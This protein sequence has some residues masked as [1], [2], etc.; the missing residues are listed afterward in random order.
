[1]PDMTAAQEA[2]LETLCNNYGVGFDPDDYR[3]QFDLPAGWV[4]GW[5]G[6][7]SQRDKT[8]YVGVSPEGESHS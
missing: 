4:G 6:G 7:L 2:R 1:M 8:L 3:P 5:V